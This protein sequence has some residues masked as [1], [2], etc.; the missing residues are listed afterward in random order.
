MTV[1]ATGSSNGHCSNT[2]TLPSDW[3][4]HLEDGTIPLYCSFLQFISIGGNGLC[5]SIV[6]EP[7]NGGRHDWSCIC[8]V[9]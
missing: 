8:C 5:I 7:V 3:L 1:M 4:F 2:V 6:F 9:L